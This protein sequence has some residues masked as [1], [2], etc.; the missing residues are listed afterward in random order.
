MSTR[1]WNFFFSFKPHFG[2]LNVL[3]KQVVEIFVGRLNQ[4]FAFLFF[5]CACKYNDLTI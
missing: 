1:F 3:I 2:D 5:L 4:V